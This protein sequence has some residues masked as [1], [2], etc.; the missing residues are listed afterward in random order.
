M[1]FFHL[2]R[3]SNFLYIYSMA[4]EKKYNGTEKIKRPAI[5]LTE[6]QHKKIGHYCVDHDLSI[7]DFFTLSAMYIVDNDIDLKK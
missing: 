3:M 1:D 2:D 4:R 6:E 5:R 7:Q